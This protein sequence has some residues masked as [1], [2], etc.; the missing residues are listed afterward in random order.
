MLSLLNII[1]LYNSSDF[2]VTSA[3]SPSFIVYCGFAISPLIKTISILSFY[4]LLK[5]STG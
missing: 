2:T 5:S 4:A 3:L 1:A